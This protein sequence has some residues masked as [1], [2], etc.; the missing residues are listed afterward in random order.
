MGLVIAL[1]FAVADW[2][3]V[4]QSNLMASGVLA[5][6]LIALSSIDAHAQRLPDVITLPLIVS[7]LSVAMLD[8]FQAMAWSA[9]GA[10]VGYGLITGLGWYWRSRRG[11]DGIGQGDA[12]LLAAGGAWCGLLSLP[13]IL[14]ISSFSGLVF[15]ALFARGKMRHQKIAFGPFLCAAIWLVWAA[16]PA[17]FTP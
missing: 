11:M 5:L 1:T 12:K 4:L 14:L 16:A 6:A 2:R 13:P 10:I 9:S 3:A 17:P 8:S 7:G 15:A